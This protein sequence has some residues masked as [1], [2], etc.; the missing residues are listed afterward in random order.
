MGWAFKRARNVDLPAIFLC[1]KQERRRQRRKQRSLAWDV[2]LSLSGHFP[3]AGEVDTTLSKNYCRAVQYRSEI[4]G[5][6]TRKT[7]AQFL[8]KRV[9]KH[10]LARIYAH[11]MRVFPFVIHSHQW[12][13]SP[14]SLNR[15]QFLQTPVKI[16]PPTNKQLISF[17]HA[18]GVD[19]HPTFTQILLLWTGCKNNRSHRFSVILTCAVAVW[20]SS[21]LPG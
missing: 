19:K 9:L 14:S 20:I 1:L 18:H 2:A 3:A 13:S 4:S 15:R 5:L 16:S 12:H 10:A 17:G 6:R 8:H 7:H 11:L 21:L